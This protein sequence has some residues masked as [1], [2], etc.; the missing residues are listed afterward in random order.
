MKTK[1]FFRLIAPRLLIRIFQDD[2]G[3]AVSTTLSTRVKFRAVELS[4]FS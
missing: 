1:A 3:L 2:Q 4:I